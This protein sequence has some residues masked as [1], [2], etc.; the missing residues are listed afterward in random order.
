MQYLFSVLWILL[1]CSTGT[2]V[3]GDADTFD[4]DDDERA[5]LEQFIK[6]VMEEHG[7]PGMTVAIVKVGPTCLKIS[8]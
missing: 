4:E 2:S 7:V 6:D 8:K 1:I 5:R 3:Y